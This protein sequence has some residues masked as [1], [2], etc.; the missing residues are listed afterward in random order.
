MPRESRRSRNA[1]DI[2]LTQSGNSAGTDSATSRQ[3]EDKSG[4]KTCYDHIEDAERQ[5]GA[6][7]GPSNFLVK[8]QVLDSSGED[9]GP[10]VGWVRDLALENDQTEELGLRIELP[11]SGDLR[12]RK[13]ISRSRRV[14]TGKYP[15]WKMCRLMHWESRLESK[16]FRLLDVCPAVE[17]F[18]EQPFTIHYLSE[19][20][21]RSHV[22]DVAF[23]DKDGVIWI[24]EVKSNL[25]P[26]VPDA[27]TRAMEIAPRLNSIG[28]KY[29]VVREQAIRNGTS[30][31]NAEAIM[32]FGRGEP[33]AISQK[34]ISRLL[35]AQ[36][37]LSRSDLVGRT[38]DGEHAFKAAA[39]LALRGQISLNWPDGNYQPL[40]IQRLRDE[41][42]EE[43][44][45]WLLHAL[46]VTK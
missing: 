13:L 18:A 34:E 40:E 7:S 27:M 9:A 33:T 16:V 26:G 17:K 43:S 41:N 37:S 19:E 8:P 25:D 14:M 21:W 46:G 39:Q 42:A 15:S 10:I 4:I 5:L 20:S 12:A 1:S 24:L 30:L 28:L 31:S 11:P 6:P 22:P 35:I 29:A 23:V 36:P 45:S 3:R 2:A 32:R 44:M 38:I